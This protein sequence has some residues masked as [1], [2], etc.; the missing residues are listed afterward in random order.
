LIRRHDLIIRKP[1]RLGSVRARIM[2]SEVVSKYYTDHATLVDTLDLSDKPQYIWNCKESGISFKHDP[3]RVITAKGASSL[4][5]AKQAVSP[6]IWLMACVNA[7]GNAGCHACLS[8]KVNHPLSTCFQHRR[9]PGR[10]NVGVPAK[11][12]DARRNWWKVVQSGFWSN[13]GPYRPQLL[14]LDGH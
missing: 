2:H 11:W 6:T 8:L 1:E 9:S 5:L 7:A 3:V 10:N 14:I 4:S 12:L 13:C